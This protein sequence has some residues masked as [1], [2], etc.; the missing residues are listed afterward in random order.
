MNL[1]P[2]RVIVCTSPYPNPAIP[3]RAFAEV[4]AS[5][6]TGVVA[7]TITDFDPFPPAPVHAKL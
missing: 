6:D 7:C 3:A 1:S 4:I 5:A 2:F